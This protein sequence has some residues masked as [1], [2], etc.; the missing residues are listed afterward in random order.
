M[1]LSYAHGTSGTP[2]LGETV[3]ANLD[4]T[5]ERFPDA[6]ALVS[7]HQGV[8]MTYAQ[9]GATVDVV[10]GGL[11]DL[12]IAAGD[13][14]G[15][16]SPNSAEWVLLQYA[17]A[18]VGAVLVSINTAFRQ[19]ELQHA[20]QLSGA[21]LLIAAE[22]A[23]SPDYREVIDRVLPDVDRLERVL[24]LGTADWD[25]LLSAGEMVPAD[26]LRARSATVRFDDPAN[27]MFTSG[28]TG[29]PK[30]ATM[31]HH[32]NLNNGYL[33][34]ERS[35][36]T[37]HDRVCLPIP[38]HHA[39]GSVCGNIACTSHGACI[40]LPGPA[41][42]PGDVLDTLQVERCTSLYGVPTMF[43]AQLDHA[44]FDQYE[45][46][47]L[48]TGIMGGSP[49]PRE[50][51]DQVISRMHID[52]IT[53]VYG[54]TE[55]MVTTMTSPDDDI[56]RRVSTVGPALPHVELKIV[57]AG[58]G[59]T[60][61]P[62]GVAG[63]LCARGYSNMLGYWGDDASTAGIV[64]RARWLHTGDL[65]VMDDDGY[66]RIVGR[67]KDMIIRGG[68]NVYP[69]EVENF[70]LGHPDIADV[71]VMGVPDREYGEHVLAC[72][73]TVPGADLTVDAVR[74][75]C[76]GRIAYFK[77]PH[78]VRFVAEFPMTVSGKV[79]KYKLRELAISEL[80]L[81]L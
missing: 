50:L 2:L 39:F 38:L 68:I 4:R 64:D 72:I 31:S 47:T 43:I 42:E 35:G 59:A 36:C 34:G 11:L 28:T 7:R 6:D 12:G 74:E 3:G 63:E 55:T 29:A 16:W 44:G 48:R 62:R 25:N 5:V 26:V 46:S 18:K 76:E 24:H 27:I 51:M 15:L 67:I 30:G 20:L 13:R 49:C 37:R 9:F 56:E 80:E 1:V 53:I 10:A 70:L 75:Y 58:D 69:S 40:V 77:V 65:A 54:M 66:L 60:V 33:L 21:R 19:R 14:V 22:S 32:G 79:Q 52:Q 23:R 78:Y 57:D 61:V 45:L 17:A 41:F 8:R 71:A 81:A 73:R